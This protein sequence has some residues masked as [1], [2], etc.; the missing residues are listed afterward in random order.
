MLQTILPEGV[1]A[2][3]RYSVSREQL[4]PE[5]R[6]SFPGGLS[7][8]RAAEFATGRTCAHAAL[9]RLTGRMHSVRRAPTR[10]PIWPSGVVG[11]ITHCAGYYAAAVGLRTHWSAIGIDAEANAPL[12]EGVLSLIATENERKHLARL[13]QTRSSDTK[14]HYD[15]LLFS[16]KECVYKAWYPLI[17]TPLEYSQVSVFLDSFEHTYR[18]AI[19]RKDSSCLTGNCLLK[20]RFACSDKFILASL[21]VSLVDG[22]VALRENRRTSRSVV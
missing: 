10:E 18:V 19:H 22:S 6:L 15:R 11:S 4:T 17:R 21:C 13:E 8:S 12:P 5:E 1:I 14:V 20:G 9:Y 2:E 7:L 3:Q 16:V